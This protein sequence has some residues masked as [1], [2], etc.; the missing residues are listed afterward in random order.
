MLRY[1]LWH[2]LNSS[3]WIV[4]L[5]CVLG[6]I[7]LS[8]GTTAID[9]HFDYGL[10]PQTFTG[11]PTAAQNILST[12]AS[13]MMTL[14]TLVLTITTVAV[15]LAMGQFSPRIVRALLSDR[16]NQL[17][18][19]LFAAAFTYP[20][21][22]LRVVDDQTGTVP[23]L[24]VVVTYLLTLASVIVLILYIDHASQALRVAGLIDLVGDNLDEQLNAFPPYQAELTT[25]D[26]DEQVVVAQE[27]G[28]I[29]WVD[30]KGLVDAARSA[31]C[32]LEMLPMMGDFVPAGAPLFRVQGEVAGLDSQQLVQL[33]AFAN[34]RTHDADPAFGFRK[35]V[36]IAERSIAQAFDDPTTSVQAIHRLHNGLRQLAS[37]QLPSGWHYDEEGHL[38]L[39]IR[40]LSW[41]G[42]VRL[43]FD[44][45]RL[46]GA[47]QPQVTRRLKTALEDLKTIVPPERQPA[48]D[49]QLKKL[50][51]L[52][53]R[54]LDDEEDI[55]AS[56][57]ADSQGIGSGKDVIS[58]DS[59]PES[60]LSGE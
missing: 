20:L 1:R 22:I 45:L 18:I 8:V 53:E 16:W 25:S 15:Q 9:R 10:I 34:E 14:I 42:Y 55:S 49:R 31:G 57:T 3:I 54:E 6:S 30:H 4:P 13:S 19:G 46:V 26:Q 32:M 17:A 38:R 21:L 37:R 24:G 28:V 27:V 11:G 56:L 47:G 43:A 12:I 23:G 5:V 39:V 51:E 58:T 59:R 2:T 7:G 29:V 60:P 48:L 35:L 40:T 50:K 36:D 52:V 44:E 33:V 41:E